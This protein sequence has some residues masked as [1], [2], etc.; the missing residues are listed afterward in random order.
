MPDDTNAQGFQIGGE[1]GDLFAGAA[2]YYAQYRRPIPD[3]IVSFLVNQCGLDRSGR[4]LDVGCGTGQ[5][6]IPLA[7]YFAETT[8]IDADRAMIETARKS[9]SKTNIQWTQMRA[10]EMTSD[11]GSFRMVIFGASFHWMDRLRVSEIVYELLELGGWLVI[12]CPSELRSGTAPW[13]KEIQTVLTEEI[14]PQRRAGGGIYQQGELH[15]DILQQSSFRTCQITSI[16]I[17]ES[18]SIEEISGYLLSTSYASPA[19]LKEKQE[20]LLHTLRRRLLAL[21]PAGQ[22]SKDTTHT[23]ISAQKA[24]ATS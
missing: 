19:V 5:T 23:V 18:W 11:L 6:C 15:Q 20:R 4:L 14:G 8:A 22:F 10:E 1:P 2:D 7:P 3:A 13:E 12:S 17:N 16:A 9:N 24:S 21:N